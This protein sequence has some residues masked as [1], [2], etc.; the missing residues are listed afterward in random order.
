GNAASEVNDVI[1]LP[2]TSIG[3]RAADFGTRGKR[4]QRFRVI[5]Y[6]LRIRSR[7]TA[8]HHFDGLHPITL[9]PLRAL[10][11]GMRCPSQRRSTSDANPI[12]VSQSPA[13]VQSQSPV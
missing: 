6:P 9:V 11:H 2:Q 1:G 5:N 8:Q 13:A 12:A 3:A 10:R 4:L 7:M